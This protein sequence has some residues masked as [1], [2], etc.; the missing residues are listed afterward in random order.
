MLAPLVAVSLLGMQQPSN[1]IRHVPSANLQILFSRDMEPVAPEE[2]SRKESKGRLGWETESIWLATAP[3]AWVRLTHWT[4]AKG[5]KPLMTPKEIA[6]ELYTNSELVSTKEELE[7]SYFDRKVIDAKVGPYPA[8][9]DLHLDKN[10]NRHLAFLAFGDEK[11]QWFVEI[12]GDAKLEGM[13]ASIRSMVASVR[14]LTTPKGQLAKGLTR[15]MNLPG[16]GFEIAAPA[17]FT[18]RV[19]VPESGR[20]K[21]WAHWYTLDLTDDYMISVQDHAYADKQQPNLKRDLDDVVNSLKNS[22]RKFG[23]PVD[24]EGKQDGWTT[25]VRVQ[26]CTHDGKAYTMAWS[27]WASPGRTI[28]TAVKIADEIGGAVHAPEIAQSLRPAKTK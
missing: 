13:D 5:K 20:K 14:P 7:Q 11:E 21:L 9:V 16:T 4:Y 2:S 27:Y 28:F 26:P 8:T 10:E 23:A 15:M 12:S 22:G 6:T 17:S 19:A 18:A 3:R 25:L 1:L 24:K